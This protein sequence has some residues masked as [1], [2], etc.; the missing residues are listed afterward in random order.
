MSGI[1]A[2]PQIKFDD[3]NQGWPTTPHSPLSSNENNAPFNIIPLGSKDNPL[4]WDSVWIL[5]NQG[6]FTGFLQRP[7]FAQFHDQ[8][9]HYLKSLKGQ[10][11]KSYQEPSSGHPGAVL[12][13]CIHISIFQKI[14]FIQIE[15]Y[16]QIKHTYYSLD[17][18]LPH[19]DYIRCTPG[20]HEW[21]WFDTILVD[22]GDSFRPARLHLVFSVQVHVVVWQLAWVTYFTALPSTPID[23]AI[24]M[25]QYK[26][27]KYG[28]FI[29]LASIIQSCYMTPIFAAPQQFY[30][31]DLVAGDV[32]LF[33]QL[34]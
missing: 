8:L 28:E 20:F 4:D 25:K 6:Y 11:C 5:E 23:H 1:K 33:L 7:Q 24:G 15:P 13:V 19:Q 26:E 12:L 30:M 16:Q 27:E 3:N 22:V 18:Q 31:N 34:K 21:D 9:V 10:Y 29:H 17:D 14:I 2:Q 32:D